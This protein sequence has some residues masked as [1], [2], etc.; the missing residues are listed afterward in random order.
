MKVKF[1]IGARLIEIPEGFERK[2]WKS[3]SGVL[4]ENV[5][6]GHDAVSR[7]ESKIL[8]KKHIRIVYKRKIM[9]LLFFLSACIK[10]RFC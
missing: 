5:T 8:S 6:G 4:M 1:K 7:V 3:H 2:V 9:L 10:E